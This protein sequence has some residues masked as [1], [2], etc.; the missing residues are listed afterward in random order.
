MNGP[1]STIKISATGNVTS[2]EGEYVFLTASGGDGNEHGSVAE[3]HI[4]I[5]SNNGDFAQGRFKADEL[6][7]AIAKAR[8]AGEQ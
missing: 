5:H 7:A 1:Y 3:V 8:K 6:E 4:Q 2:S